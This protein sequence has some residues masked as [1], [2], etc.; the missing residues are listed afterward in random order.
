METR[1]HITRRPRE[2]AYF[3]ELAKG[4]DRMEIVA[5]DSHYDALMAANGIAA[6]SGLRVYDYTQ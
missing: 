5:T 1:I 2:A 4:A 3:V 6:W